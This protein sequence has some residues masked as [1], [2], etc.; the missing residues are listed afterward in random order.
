M[1]ELPNR[2]LLRPDEVAKYFRLSIST[3]H[4]WINAGKLPAIRLPGKSI[5]IARVTIEDIKN[6][7]FE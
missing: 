3:I 7:A 4:A 2:E 1:N 6:S 5:R